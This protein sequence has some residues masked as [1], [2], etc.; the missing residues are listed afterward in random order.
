MADLLKQQG[1][2]VLVAEDPHQALQMNEGRALDLLITDVVIPYMTGPELRAR[3]LEGCPGL[4]V[5]YMSGYTSNVIVHKGELD[6]GI[7]LIQKP[8]V[9][10]EFARRV[11][12]MLA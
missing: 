6:K 12:M 5:L 11:K 1:F 8:F 2:E 10:T 9:V 4:K 7:H 3:L